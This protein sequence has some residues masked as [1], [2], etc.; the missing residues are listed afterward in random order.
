MG[1]DRLRLP[2]GRFAGTSAISDF[3]DWFVAPEDRNAAMLHED[4][5]NGGVQ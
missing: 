2:P 5:Y 3:R 4:R 1:K